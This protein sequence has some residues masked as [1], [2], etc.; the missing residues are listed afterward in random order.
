MGHCDSDMVLYKP[1][2]P[3]RHRAVRMTASGPA[4]VALRLGLPIEKGV[5]MDIGHSCNVCQ[6][7]KSLAVCWIILSLDAS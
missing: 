3:L 7:T 6:G 5:F 1:Q 4:A 2:S